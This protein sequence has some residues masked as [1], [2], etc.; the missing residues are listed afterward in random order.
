M[1]GIGGEY[2]WKS[3]FQG[4]ICFNMETKLLNLQ[5]VDSKL[6]TCFEKMG[7]RVSSMATQ[8]SLGI[9]AKCDLRF[10]NVPIVSSFQFRKS[11]TSHGINWVTNWDKRMSFLAWVAWTRVLHQRAVDEE[12][13]P[14][15]SWK[16][17]NL[18]LVKPN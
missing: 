17:L 5:R 3:H 4:N 13:W 18:G 10:P 11:P 16:L 15:D 6:E 8:S 14:T 7:R 9:V 12:H 1:E 2:V